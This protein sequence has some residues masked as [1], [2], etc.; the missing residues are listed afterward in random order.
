[1]NF[2]VI[3]HFHKED[4]DP[5]ID[6]YKKIKNHVN[7][8]RFILVSPEEAC[9]IKYAWNCLLATKISFYNEIKQA[10]KI[11]NVDIRKLLP[12]LFMDQTKTDE[13][14]KRDFLTHGFKD[15]CLPKDLTSFSTF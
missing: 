15:E 2:T 4:A 11:F 10:F 7:E 6:V 9:L 5:L 12:V 1:M 14:C 3:G 8:F 13:W